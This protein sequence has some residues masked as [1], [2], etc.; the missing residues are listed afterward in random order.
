M[1]PK[2]KAEA[3]VEGLAELGNSNHYKKSLLSQ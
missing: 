2:V 1:S 3:S